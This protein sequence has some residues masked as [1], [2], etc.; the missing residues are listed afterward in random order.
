MQEH[1]LYMTY[2]HVSTNWRNSTPRLAHPFDPSFPLVSN[3]Y[4]KWLSQIRTRLSLAQL[5][6]LASSLSLLYI[7]GSRKDVPHRTSPWNGLLSVLHR[8]SAWNPVE[9]ASSVWRI[10]WWDAVS[11]STHNNR[12]SCSL[13]WP[14]K[15]YDNPKVYHGGYFLNDNVSIKAAV[16]IKRRF[17]ELPCKWARVTPSLQCT[18]MGC[19]SWKKRI[20]LII[21]TRASADLVANRS[22]SVRPCAERGVGDNDECAA[23]QGGFL[24]EIPPK[25]QPADPKIKYRCIYDIPGER[26]SIPV[27][28]WTEDEVR[29]SPKL[30]PGQADQ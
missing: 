27:R 3:K 29:I 12:T 6:Q 14:N 1:G 30:N 20:T 18:L 2:L 4:K 7:Q 24:E 21:Q 26:T 16:H 25:N 15:A 17:T 19:K 23:R 5:Q 8:H 11:F 13:L 28:F 10:L 9:R 22:R